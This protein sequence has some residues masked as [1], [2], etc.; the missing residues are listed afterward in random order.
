MSTDGRLPEI[1]VAADVEADGPIPGAFS[2]LSLGMARRRT[3]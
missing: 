1:Y 2:M 3:S